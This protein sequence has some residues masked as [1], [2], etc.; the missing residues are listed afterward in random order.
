M[1]S[2]VTFVLEGTTVPRLQ[3]VYQN[4]GLR[5]GGACHSFIHLDILINH[6]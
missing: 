3:V 4:P 6:F 5:R 2:L 1:S